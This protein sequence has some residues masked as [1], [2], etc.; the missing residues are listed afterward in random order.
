MD[1]KTIIIKLL[2]VYE[3]TV[4][5]LSATPPPMAYTATDAKQANPNSCT[6]YIGPGIADN[7][8]IAGK[9]LDR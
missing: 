6:V 7:P 9:A 4:S 5:R 3:W 1:I 8:R 2:G